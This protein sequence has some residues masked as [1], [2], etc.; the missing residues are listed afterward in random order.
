MAL[1]KITGYKFT[2]E[3]QAEQAVEDC[4]IYYHIPENP[5]D[6]TQ[7]WTRYWDGKLDDLTFW[8]IYYDESLFPVLG[9]PSEFEIE[10]NI[11]T[12]NP[13]V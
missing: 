7:S 11:Q 1:I 3:S 5:E 13:D 4:N 10:I 2:L 6:V 8:Y 12:N 9:I